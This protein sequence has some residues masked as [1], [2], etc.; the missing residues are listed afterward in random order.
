MGLETAQ[1]INSLDE[2]YPTGLDSRTTADDH[3]RLIKAS[4]KRTFPSITSAIGV[5]DVQLNYVMGLSSS[6][7]DQINALITGKMYNS[8][9][10]AF[11]ISANW[12]NSANY[13]L[14]AGAASDATLAARAISADNAGSAVYAYSASFATS[15]YN[16][17]S[18]VYAYSTTNATSAVFA[19]SANAAASAQR[20]VQLQH[21]GAVVISAADYT[22]IGT[23]AKI[24]DGAGS[25][26]PVGMNV[27]PILQRLGGT[28][29]LRIANV[30]FNQYAYAASVIF[31][32][33]TTTD[34]APDGSVWIIS[35]FQTTNSASITA[36]G[37][38]L[39]WFDGVGAPLTGTRT[40]APYGYCTV[41]KYSNGSYGIVGV[42]LS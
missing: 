26:Q 32:M 2:T 39:Y 18:A 19:T 15:A 29:D 41:T 14:S 9:T 40:L 36:T 13:A 1:Y 34:S 27:T 4:L 33:D 30:G 20:A 11:A 28:H 10:A 35:N 31:D 22:A 23:G 25:Q 3:L 42:G 12:A 24:L 38:S 17:N 5:T 7:Q 8:A 37:V 16:A 6:A 21:A